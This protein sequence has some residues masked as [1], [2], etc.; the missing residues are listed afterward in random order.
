ML[1]KFSSEQSPA[2]SAIGLASALMR[3]KCSGIP[4]RFRIS[5]TDALPLD[6]GPRQGH[7]RLGGWRALRR[8]ASPLPSTVRC[9]WAP[10]RPCQWRGRYS[11][12]GAALE[13][14]SFRPAGGG[15]GLGGECVAGAPKPNKKA[16]IEPLVEQ[17]CGSG[18]RVH[19]TYLCRSKGPAA[20]PVQ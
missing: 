11:P 2:H 4:K 6:P 8:S 10:R 3:R 15:R 14:E 19:G 12:S 17:D 7:E 5:R 20:S 13:A 9:H 1:P 18:R 16:G